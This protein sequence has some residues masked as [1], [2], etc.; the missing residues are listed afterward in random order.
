VTWNDL[1]ERAAVFEVTEADVRAAL[2]AIR[3]EDG[4]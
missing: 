3:G 2:D 4:E 1:Y